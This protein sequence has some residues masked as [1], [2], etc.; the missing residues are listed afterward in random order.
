ML[1]VQK[2][3][4]NAALPVRS[5]DGAHE[6]CSTH[7]QVV[8]AKHKA[9]IKNA[10]AVCAPCDVRRHVVAFPAFAWRCHVS[11]AGANAHKRNIAVV[12]FNHGDSGLV[13]RRG[14]AIPRLLLQRVAALEI[15]EV[16]ELPGPVVPRATETTA[17]PKC[18]KCR[19]GRRSA[20]AVEK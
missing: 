8:T 16:Q 5:S 13:I 14:D 18:R 19:R 9:V 6:L 12:W 17:V 11:V 3:I 20:A 15:E 4:V 1:P 2:L 7:D 10:C